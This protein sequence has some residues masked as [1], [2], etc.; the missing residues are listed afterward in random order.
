MSEN[1]KDAGTIAALMDRFE[2][3]RLPRALQIKEKVFQGERLDD[4][5]IDFLKQVFED[6]HQVK[7]LLDRHPEY[8]TLVVRAIDLYKEITDKALENEQ[9]S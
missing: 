9:N 6:A 3:Q 5:D 8:Q 4:V 7:P 1:L 2:H